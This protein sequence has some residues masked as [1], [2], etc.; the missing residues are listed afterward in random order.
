[1]SPDVRLGTIYKGVLPFCTADF[2]KL[3]LLVLFPALST[4]LP[5][6]MFR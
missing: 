5:S 3:A 1:M 6:T 2:V 4:W